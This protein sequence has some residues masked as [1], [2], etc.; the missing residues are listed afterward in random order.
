MPVW[1]EGKSI[2]FMQHHRHN[3]KIVCRL[4]GAKSW[5]QSLWEGSSRK[6]GVEHNLGRDTGAGERRAVL[7]T[8]PTTWKLWGGVFRKIKVRDIC[9]AE[10]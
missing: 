4:E 1:G 6:T 9:W 7:A 5:F 3:A 8:G 2:L 10:F